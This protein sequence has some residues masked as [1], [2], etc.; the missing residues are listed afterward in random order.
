MRGSVYSGSLNSPGLHRC[1]FSLGVPSRRPKS[2]VLAGAYRDHPFGKGLSVS[3]AKEVPRCRRVFPRR[4]VRASLEGW[5]R[6]CRQ[7]Q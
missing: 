6:G 5:V 3:D 7:S 1:A 2:G 4:Y